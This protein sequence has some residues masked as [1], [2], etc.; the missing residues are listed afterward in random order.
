MIPQES[1][2]FANEYGETSQGRRILRIIDA[3]KRNH[4]KYGESYCPCKV[5]RIPD[6]ICPCKEYRDTGKCICGLY[7]PHE[8][9]DN[10]KLT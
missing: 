1:I 3:L 8:S 2:D 5:D 7:L 6:N 9:Y 10:T 4:Q